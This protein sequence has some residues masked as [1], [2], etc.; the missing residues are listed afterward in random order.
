[1]SEALVI[2]VGNP[3]RGDDGVGPAVAR[4]LAGTPGIQVAEC[5]GEP[6]ELMQC[7]SGYERVFLVDALVTGAAPGSLLRLTAETP[8]PRPARHSSHGL[9]LAEAIELARALDALPPE[10]V[11]YGIE[12][13]SLADGTRL[14]PAAASG[15]AELVLSIQ[16]ELHQRKDAKTQKGR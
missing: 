13:E 11:I 12:A 2:G 15:V 10:L 8:L 7:W 16:S 14:S 9:G 5:G 1:M 4:L 6:A 3:W